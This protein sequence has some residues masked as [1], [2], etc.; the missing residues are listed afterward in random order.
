M[1]IKINSRKDRGS[2]LV[3]VVIR[4]I[5]VIPAVFIALDKDIRWLEKIY[6]FTFS[7]LL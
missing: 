5:S 1:D 7:L 3:S 4:N 2:V 6:L